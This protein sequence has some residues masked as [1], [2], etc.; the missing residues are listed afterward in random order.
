MKHSALRTR[1]GRTGKSAPN[2]RFCR[3]LPIATLVVSA[4]IS[5][6]GQQALAASVNNA[7]SDLILDPLHVSIATRLTEV[8]RATLNGRDF[9]TLHIGGQEVGPSSCRSNTL[10]MDT[11]TFEGDKTHAEME[12][13][14]LTAMLTNES[15]MI[16]VPLDRERCV[17]GMPTFTDLYKL[18]R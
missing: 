13:I 17:D 7:Q 14:A 2:R 1:H 9:L 5:S 16:V 18:S 4:L 15:V 12:T 11:T 6:T 8:Q 10:R 3:V